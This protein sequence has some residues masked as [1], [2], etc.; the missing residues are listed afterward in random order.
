[1]ILLEVVFLT[2]F[3]AWV[4]AAALFLRNTILPRF[5]LVQTP[6]ALGLP[7]E[8]VRLTA[9][10]GLQL[11]GWKIP[12]NPARPWIILC[13]GV[14]ANRSDLLDIAAKLHAAGLN[15]FLF[16]FRGHGGS[17]GRTTSFGWEEQRDL[18]GALT[19]LGQ[20]A[21]VPSRPY[22]VYGISMGGSVALMV[23][24]KDERLAAVV[25]DSPYTNLEATIGRHLALLYPAM[26][27]L[28]FLPLVLATYRL[29]Y[30][31]WPRKVSPEASA[32]ALGHRGLL[33]IQGG[34]D[35]RMP[36]EGAEAITRAGGKR[37]KVWLVPGAGHLE[38]YAVD[39]AQYLK[40]LVEFFKDELR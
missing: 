7:A 32:A 33:V 20:Q 4:F 6:E 18:E 15:L 13:H 12:A 34:E 31:V 40:R 39:E 10:D 38:A 14:G 36:R 9:T 19:F 27:K 35:A 30:G 23:A 26:S 16:D 1:M 5:P 29:R 17:A 21:D 11:E 25:A 37:A 3:W 22:G 2:V 28:P 8:T 24:A